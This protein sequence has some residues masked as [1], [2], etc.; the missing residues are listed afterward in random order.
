M[1]RHYLDGSRNICRSGF[2]M[3]L[4]VNRGPLFTSFHGDYPPPGTRSSVLGALLGQEESCQKRHPAVRPPFPAPPLGPW[5]ARLLSTSSC[6]VGC[7]ITALLLQEGNPEGVVLLW[8]GPDISSMI[9]ELRGEGLGSMWGRTWDRDK[10]L[11]PPSWWEWEVGADEGSWGPWV[12][13]GPNFVDKENGLIQ[14]GSSARRA[15]LQVSGTKN[16]W[17]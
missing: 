8:A 2:T 1:K 12:S 13:N 5:A 11:K 3:E 10:I 6:N 14:A 16:C 7:V 15:R 4:G 9:W 17:E